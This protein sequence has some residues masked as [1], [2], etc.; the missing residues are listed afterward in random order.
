MFNGFL[1]L[2]E[3]ARNWRYFSP[4]LTL[5]NQNNKPKV[6]DYCNFLFDLGWLTFPRRL[7]QC[8]YAVLFE[9]Y[10]FSWNLHYIIQIGCGQIKWYIQIKI[11]S[12]HLCIWRFKW[13]TWH[14]EFAH[15]M[16]NYLVKLWT[17]L[18][19]SGSTFCGHI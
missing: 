9:L 3:G 12:P 5:V 18:I 6:V 17:F 14:V 11:Y 7:S 19:V 8:I 1:K 16:H 10:G 13:C 15:N 2:M 4:M